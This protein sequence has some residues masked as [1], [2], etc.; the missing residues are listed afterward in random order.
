MGEIL[1]L[2]DNESLVNLTPRQ[3]VD[4]LVI[5]E[6]GWNERLEALRDAVDFCDK[7]V[8]ES[9]SVGIDADQNILDMLVIDSMVENDFENRRQDK[10]KSILNKTVEY[11]MV[12]GQTVDYIG[13]NFCLIDS[14]K[15][16]LEDI[17]KNKDSV[18]PFGILSGR[19][20]LVEFFGWGRKEGFKKQF[21]TMVRGVDERVISNA[22]DIL[23][24]NRKRGNLGYNPIISDGSQSRDLGNKMS[25]LVREGFFGLGVRRRVNY[26][27]KA[28][29][30]PGQENGVK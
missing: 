22:Y 4:S 29:I 14:L 1:K 24:D 25:D 26:I 30:Q 11:V 18:N 13:F 9:V 16:V 15:E 21:R 6:P 2:I 27:N 17:E 20:N 10:M 28:T 7:N 12:F 19:M 8:I 5:F 23:L 3:F